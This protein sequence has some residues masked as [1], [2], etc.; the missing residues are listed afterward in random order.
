MGEVGSAR[1]CMCVLN[2]KSTHQIE[3]MFNVMLCLPDRYQDSVQCKF[4]VCSEYSLRKN[5]QSEM[6]MF[7]VET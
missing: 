5:V 1:L 6:S 7:F 2:N 4:P 3:R